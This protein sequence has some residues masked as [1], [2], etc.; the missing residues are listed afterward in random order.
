[1]FGTS[2]GLQQQPQPQVQQLAQQLAPAQQHFQI[3]K[4]L[5][6]NELPKE[7]Q[8]KLNELQ[9]TTFSHPSNR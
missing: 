1:M 8:Q 3:H 9:Y 4:G 5:K 6:Y 7:M 2:F